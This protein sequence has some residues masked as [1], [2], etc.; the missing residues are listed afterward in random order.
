MQNSI[1]FILRFWGEE[2]YKYITPIM[3]AGDNSQG[4]GRPLI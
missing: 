2:G 1:L 3:V 4:W